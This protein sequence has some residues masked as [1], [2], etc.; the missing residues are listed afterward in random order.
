M[1]RAKWFDTE[2]WSRAENRGAWELRLMAWREAGGWSS[3]ARLF[4]R[5]EADPRKYKTR[6]AAKR[7]AIRLARRLLTRALDG[8]PE[9]C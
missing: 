6:D 7:A 2:T 9:E 4:G 3:D 8:L 1:K 5:T